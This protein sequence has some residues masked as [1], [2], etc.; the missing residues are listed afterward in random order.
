M[1]IAYLISA[2]TDPAHLLKLVEALHVTAEYFIHVDAKSDIKPFRDLMKGKRNVHFVSSRV[3]MVGGDMSEVEAQMILL[4]SAL[5]NRRQFDYFFM[6][7]GM[8][9]PLW[10]NERISQFLRQHKGKEFIYGIDLDTPEVKMEHKE[11]YRIA[12]PM[13]N[14]P[15]V[16]RDSLSKVRSLLKRA[17]AATGYRKPLNFAV[18]KKTYHL[19]KGSAWF[20]ISQNLAEYVVGQYKEVP[21]IKEYFSNQFG[22]VTTLI[23]TIVF[24]SEHADRCMLKIGNYTTLS[25]ITPL[26]YIDRDTGMKVMNESDYPLMMESGKMFVR[27][28]RTGESGTLVELIDKH[29]AADVEKK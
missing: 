1:N 19:F 27:K 2:H 24:N 12:R 17:I 20:C 8:D 21:E 6:L 14:V 9:Y 7:S 10:S 29:R 28:V 23:H 25:D 13:P 18:G 16:G 22:P 3:E 15:F 11:L 4:E 5:R 26:H